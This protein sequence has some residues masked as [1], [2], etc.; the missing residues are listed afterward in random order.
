MRHEKAGTLLDL[1][2]H[3]ASSAEGL[4][5]DEMAAAVGVGRRTA[6]RM[7]D[8]LYELFPQMEEVAD[9]PSK[10]FRI[11]QGLDG[12]F[13]SPT[14]EELLELNKAAAGLH[15]AGADSRGRALESLERKVRS[16]IRSSTLR[17]MVPDVEALV[18]AET[19]AV[20]A[21]PRPFEDETLIAT[22]RHA[23]MAMK[24]LR[25]S[26]AG[27]RTPGAART[28][29]PYGLMFGRSNYL[30]A[31]EF[32][33]SSPQT[34]RLDRLKY[35]ETLDVAA[36]PP[37]DFNLQDYANRSFGIYQS[38]VEEVVLRILPHGAEEALGWR[39]HPTQTAEQQPDGSVIV[40]FLAS[41]ML[42]LAWHLFTWGDKV[43][44]LG[45]PSLEQAMLRE[46]AIA[47]SH[48]E[49]TTSESGASRVQDVTP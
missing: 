8:A 42:E 5:L 17:R 25:F 34:W 13:Q 21:G 28:V 11:Q 24:A 20:Q 33:M 3:L 32:G 36:A 6:E 31:A 44:I 23:L 15:S 40:K 19:I 43:E 26:Y 48:H 30:V 46:L 14:T 2:R 49:A 1:A 38:D 37:Q 12:F 7:R 4:T 10:R 18:R 22:I 27:G 9:G 47:L 35:V 29:I 45:P 41:G 16:A 39:F